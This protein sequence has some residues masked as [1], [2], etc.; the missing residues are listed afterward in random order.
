VARLEAKSRVF[1]FLVSDHHPVARSR[2]KNLAGIGY[3]NLQ[4]VSTKR[5]GSVLPPS[6]AQGIDGLWSAKDAD[7]LAAAVM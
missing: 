2:S 4:N 1:E 6:R 5:I 3:K 7:S